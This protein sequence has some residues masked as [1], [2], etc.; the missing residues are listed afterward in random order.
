MWCEE[1]L[2]VLEVQVVEV[3]ILFCAFFLP[4]VTSASQQDF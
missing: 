3:L 2:Y 4:S 1:A